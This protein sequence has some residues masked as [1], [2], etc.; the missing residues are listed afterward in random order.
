MKKNY[1]L[2]LLLGFSVNL[3]AQVGVGTT[4]PEQMLH[5]SG[6]VS[7][8][9]AAD[10]YQL[11]KPTVRIDGLKKSNNPLV[12]SGEENYRAVYANAD[13]DL[14]LQPKTTEYLAVPMKSGE[15]NPMGNDT[16]FESLHVLENDNGT[17]KELSGTPSYTFTLE[18]TSMVTFQKQ[19]SFAIVQSGFDINDLANTAR[20]IKDGAPRVVHSLLRFTQKSSDFSGDNYDFAINSTPYVNSYDSENIMA[21]Y[22]YHN[23]SQS[24]ILPAGTYTVKL[25]LRSGSASIAETNL[26]FDTLFGTSSLLPMP[27]PSNVTI[28]ARPL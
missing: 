16:F 7:T 18:Q 1:A 10:G 9:T 21:G 28:I 5:V 27:I 23:N 14:L 8:E 11:V 17:D 12:A 13:G 26:G 3:L 22:F 19:V 20:T 24:M 2:A 15:A 6:T 25:V 4:T